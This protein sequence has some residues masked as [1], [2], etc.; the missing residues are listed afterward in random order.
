MKH[1]SQRKL[2]SQTRTIVQQMTQSVNREVSNE[3]GT[4]QQSSISL[5]QPASQ[6][7]SQHSVNASFYSVSSVP[8]EDYNIVQTESLNLQSQLSDGSEHSSEEICSNLLISHSGSSYYSFSRSSSL[9]LSRGNSFIGTESVH[10]ANNR[11]RASS[12]FV[13]SETSS[14]YNSET[15]YHSV[16]SSA[17][18]SYVSY[19]GNSIHEDNSSRSFRQLSGV[20]LLESS[21]ASVV[22]EESDTRIGDENNN[23]QLQNYHPEFT[24]HS[25]N[26]IKLILQ[27]ILD[28]IIQMILNLNIIIFKYLIEPVWKKL[29]RM[30]NVTTMVS[31]RNAN[32]NNDTNSTMLTSPNNAVRAQPNLI[33]LLFSSVGIAMIFIILYRTPYNLTNLQ[34]LEF[35]KY[36]PKIHNV[37]RQNSNLSNYSLNDDTEFVHNDLLIRDVVADQVKTVC[38]AEVQK[39]IPPQN[40]DLVRYRSNRV[41]DNDVVDM[42]RQEIKKAVE[43]MLYTYSQDKL[44]K[45]DFA[46]STGGAKIISPLTSPTFEQWPEQWYRMAFA[47]LTGHGITRGKPPVTALQPD[48]HVGQCWPFAGQKG[49]LA[50]LLSR[51]IYVTAVTYDHVSKTVAMGTTSAPKEFEIWGFADDDPDANKFDNGHSEHTST[52]TNNNYGS[53]SDI[54]LHLYGRDLKLGSSPN[55][56]FFGRFV[57]DI[58]GPPIQTFEV[59]RLNKPIRAIIMKVKNNWDNPKYTCLYRFRVHGVHPDLKSQTS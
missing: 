14:G 29:I 12:P 18:Q 43:E 53:D 39:R 48:V 21:A 54:Y 52:V 24:S 15:T 13:T 51:Q 27:E 34:N 19:D 20:Q 37:F 6:S 1:S 2:R 36:I 22:Q 40:Y 23:V 35:A 41:S 10:S 50:V 55:H 4:Q 7:F 9:S 47:K 57:Y 16:I 38:A 25:L 31:P 26:R 11:S 3:R 28:L 44:N 33:K 45:A 58:N 42:V 5:I 56:L 30:I 32:P 8:I 46:L 49:Q 59:N 17:N